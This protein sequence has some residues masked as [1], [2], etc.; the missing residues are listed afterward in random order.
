MAGRRKATLALLPAVILA[1]A[2]A[3]SPRA[4]EIAH[5]NW[6]HSRDAWATEAGLVHVNRDRVPDVVVASGDRDLYLWFAPGNPAALLR[7]LTHDRFPTPQEMVALDGRD[8][9]VLWRVKW[10]P[11][12]PPEDKTRYEFIGD[13][14]IGD[15]DDDGD[16]DILVLR[17]AYKARGNRATGLIH[18]TTLYEA[19]NG[20]VIWERRERFGAGEFSFRT[21]DPVTVGGRDYAV[22]T[23]LNN[24]Y[25]WNLSTVIEVIRFRGHRPPSSVLREVY[26]RK[27]LSTAASSDRGHLTVFAS[28]MRW[29]QQ[30][31]TTF[32]LKPA[33]LDSYKVSSG[34]RA[35]L[36]KTWSRPKAGAYPLTVLEGKNPR[37]AAGQEKVVAYNARS[38]R[39]AWRHDA[40]MSFLE[41]G[42][43]YPLDVDGDKQDDAI[44]SP[45][46]GD[47]LWGRDFSSEIHAVEGAGGQ[48][49]WKQVERAGK[50]GVRA[51]THGD[52]DGDR[53]KD[54]IASLLHNDAFPFVGHFDDDPGLVGVYDLRDG[55]VKC[56]FSTDR[57][58]R[59]V[60]SGP[61]DRARGDEV[62]APS[63]GGNT[64]AFTNAAPGC[65]PAP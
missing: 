62:I 35:R 2:L 21:I 20:R 14:T 26:P 30:S 53:K 61:M 57:L 5:V 22:V 19:S 46:L 59:A 58:S 41:P 55:S 44:L 56:R 48:Q 3:G 38:G 27:T 34:R 50:Y 64:Y 11:A 7:L 54:L 49:L 37:V 65:G 17:G 47:S 1:G 8:G 4:Q 25:D 18:R 43:I 23:A 39:V 29:V 36:V 12:V 6:I 13:L 52:V 33:P 45:V 31:E 51:F 42:N 24:D 60:L 10:G 40:R 15:F 32:T 16:R 28:G 63:L 9:S